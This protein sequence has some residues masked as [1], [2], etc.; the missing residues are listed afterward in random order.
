M[1]SYKF[2]NNRLMALRNLFESGLM[3]IPVKVYRRKIRKLKR[4]RRKLKLQKRAIKKAKRLQQ[5][6]KLQEL[7]QLE[8]LKIKYL[9]LIKPHET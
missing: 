6:Q 5:L 1:K 4:K 3:R 2:Y 7:Q 8:E 9:N